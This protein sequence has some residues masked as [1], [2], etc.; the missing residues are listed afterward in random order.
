MNAAINITINKIRI[1]ASLCAAAT[2]PALK[3]MESPGKK[4][5]SKIP[6]SKKIIAPTKR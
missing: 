1:L 3:R 5:P 6:V 4:K 2:K